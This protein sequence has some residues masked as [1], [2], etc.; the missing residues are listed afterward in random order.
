MEKK[1]LKELLEQEPW[2]YEFLAWEY[3]EDKELAI[4]A[5]N[6][7]DVFELL[8]EELQE[9][10][11]VLIAALEYDDALL[12]QLDE[13]VLEDMDIVRAAIAVFPYNYE[14]LP[15]DMQKNR[16]VALECVK[17]RGDVLECLCEELRQDEEIMEEAIRYGADLKEIA[18]GV[19]N[20]VS[21]AGMKLLKNKELVKIAMENHGGNQMCYA[22]KELWE[23]KDLAEFALE[24]GFCFLRKLPEHMAANKELV[25]R[26]VQNIPVKDYADAIFQVYSIA[27]E[28]RNDEAFMLEL[29]GLREEIFRLILRCKKG[30]GMETCFPFAVDA[31]FCKKAYQA[32]A[33]TIKYMSREMKAVVKG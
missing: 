17:V 6:N 1:K 14:S 10:K 11:D 29:I 8:P 22:A 3:K 18:G 2:V 20:S 32:N 33:K 27:E 26:V 15:E 21:E 31:A 7:G 30:E 23:N 19:L 5:V 28:L 13:S 4:A 25:K 24:H 9:D 16:E 12:E